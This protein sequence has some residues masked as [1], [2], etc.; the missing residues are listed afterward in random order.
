MGGACAQV[1]A[2]HHLPAATSDCL[3]HP[4]MTTAV[5][6]WLGSATSGRRVAMLYIFVRNAAARVARSAGPDSS[7]IGEHVHRAK[8]Y[9]SFGR[10]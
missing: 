1:C 2:C 10:L 6:H 3:R 7:Q 5:R 9:G 4:E 8:L